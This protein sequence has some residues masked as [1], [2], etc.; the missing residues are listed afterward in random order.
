MH[1]LGGILGIESEREQSNRYG[2][3]MIR[4]AFII[5]GGGKKYGSEL[6]GRHLL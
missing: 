3:R 2:R 6:R 1:G 5:D 4:G